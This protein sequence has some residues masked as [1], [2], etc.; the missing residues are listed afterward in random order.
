MGRSFVF[1]SSV[2]ERAAYAGYLVRYVLHDAVD[3]RFIFYFTKTTGFSNWIDQ[4]AISSTIGNV[5]AN[6]FANIYV[7]SPPLAEQKAIARFLDEQT[8]KI[9]DLIEAKRRLLELLKEKRQAVI[10]H[11]VT[12]GLDPNVRLKPSGIDWLGDVPEHW[13]VIPIR[14][15]SVRLQTGSTPPTQQAVY[16]E[17]A[18]VAWYGPSSF[19]DA[20]IMGL[21]ARRI[22]A[23][24]ITDGVARLFEAKS[25][26]IVTIGATLGKVGY[27]AQDSST[28][29]QITAI[30]FDQSSVMGKFAAYQLKLLES[31]LRNTAPCATLP[32]LDQQ[33]IAT[34]PM[35]LPPIAEQMQIIKY[36][37]RETAKL[38]ALAA[39]IKHA[40]SRVQEYRSA[41]ISAAVTGKIDMRR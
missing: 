3:F 41:L 11:A 15:R 29:Q 35:T 33:H 1:D 4:I 38:D 17:E 24:A 40:I 28:N 6:K 37:D 34:L 32:I 27:L 30:T 25:V 19:S 13:G 18:T 14:R 22:N 12:K 20:I 9:D 5:N 23:Q 36:I 21:P 16:Y 26:L 2:H 7:P 10:T 8:Q 31:L 39:Q